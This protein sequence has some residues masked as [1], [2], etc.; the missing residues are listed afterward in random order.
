MKYTKK[1]GRPEVL[2]GVFK[3]IR[4]K[5]I[6]LKKGWYRIPLSK[7]PKRRPLYIAFYQP[8]I[9]GEKGKLIELYGRIKYWRIKKRIEL[10][11][12]EPD[13]PDARKPYVQFFFS[14]IS[15][16]RKPVSNK[17]GLRVS[18]GFTTLARLRKGPDF[19]RILDLCPMED[20][21]AKILEREKIPF[22]RQFT[23]KGAKNNHYRLDFALPGN[24]GML[25]V[26]CDG[27]R[28]HSIKKQREMDVKRDDEL[29]VLGWKI[30]RITDEE[31]TKYP[32]EA[33]W[34]IQNLLNSA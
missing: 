13:N 17:M 14:R 10:L 24:N 21:L 6:L 22:F 12:D 25:N 28:W 16:L 26:E 4:D 27:I 18:F 33:L 15:R 11:P 30:L 19:R 5:D 7:A 1:A 20:M 9:F 8:A 2:V 23:V 34:K 31:L 32:K 3:S 29:K